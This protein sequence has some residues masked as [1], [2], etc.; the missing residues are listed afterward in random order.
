MD[1]PNCLTA[2]ERARGT[3]LACV[4]RPT[5]PCTVEAPP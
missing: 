2:D 3:I 4:A 1:E 5:A